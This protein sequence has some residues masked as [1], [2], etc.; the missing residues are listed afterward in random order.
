M[1][2]RPHE[3]LG[4]RHKIHS[5][6]QSWWRK[7]T[8][9]KSHSHD[10]SHEN[11][12]YH[13]ADNETDHGHSHHDLGMQAVF[14]HVMGDACNNLGVIAAALIMW[15]LP[16]ENIKRFYADPAMSLVIGIILIVMA[17]GLGKFPVQ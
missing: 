5:A 16:K 9:I 4:H 6:K 14:I 7:A 1:E 11:T 2:Q 8:K 3:D 13:S 15:L 10:H 17:I 12:Q